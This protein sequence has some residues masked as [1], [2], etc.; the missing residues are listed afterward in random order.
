[1]PLPIRTAALA[2]AGTL[3]AAAGAV[4][5]PASAAAPRTTAAAPAVSQVVDARVAGHRTYDRIVIDVKGRLPGATVRRVSELRY[6]GSGEKVPLS[7]RTFL[8]I[9][10]HPAVAHNSAGDPVYR[11]PR[12]VRLHLTR[13]K[14]FAFT[15]DFE[16]YVSFGVALDRKTA[17]TVHRLAS[18]GRLVVDIRH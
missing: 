2:A 3:L 7:G 11:G 15:G 8:Q 5:T 9:V 14:G 1:M 12:L 6:D 17:F 16:G 18:P 4:A 13:V 10:L